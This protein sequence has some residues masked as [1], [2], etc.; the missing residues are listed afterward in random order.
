[1]LCAHFRFML[2]AFFPL[3]KDK[4]RGFKIAA[5]FFCCLS[6]KCFINFSLIPYFHV[7]ESCFRVFNWWRHYLRAAIGQFEHSSRALLTAQLPRPEHDAIA[8]GIW[9]LAMAFCLR[10]GE[11]PPRAFGGQPSVVITLASAVFFQSIVS[12]FVVLGK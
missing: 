1:M 8:C 11:S 7:S 5:A 12:Y 10:F 3:R 6:S 4:M 9:Q 2:A